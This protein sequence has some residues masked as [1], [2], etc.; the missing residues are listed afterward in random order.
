MFRQNFGSPNFFRL[1]KIFYYLSQIPKDA[2]NNPFLIFIDRKS[3]C[4][5][6]YRVFGEQNDEIAIRIYNLFVS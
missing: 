4:K 1:F 3:I 6:F 2:Q 5:N